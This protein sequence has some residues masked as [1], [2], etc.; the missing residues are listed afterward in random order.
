MLSSSSLRR[1]AGATV[2]AALLAPAAASADTSVVGGPI[3]V[4]DYQMTLVGTDAA[5]DSLSVMFSKTVG[6]SMQMHMYSF[7]D[8]VTVTPSSIKGSLG[9]YG[10]VSLQLTGAK[11]GR[12]VVPKGCTGNPGTTKTGTLTGSFKLVAD[13]TYFKTVTAK[14]LKGSASS[15]GK[16]SCSGGQGSQGGQGGAGGPSLSL[17]ASEGQAMTTFAATDKAQSVTRMDDASAT[18]PASIM[19]MISAEGHGLEA[20]KDLAT[21]KVPAVG[22][23]MGGSGSYEGEAFS[24]GSTGTLGG[25]LVAKFDSIGAIDLRGDATIN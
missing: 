10:A 1:I 22:P 21:A 18:A 25:S 15:G 13:K 16:I 3:K 14:Q 24:G 7:D 2:A 11:K 6:G 4:R 23:F 19:H 20:A 8:G 17:F 9:R 5:K 12:G